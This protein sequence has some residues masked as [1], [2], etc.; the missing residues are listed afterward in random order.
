MVDMIPKPDFLPDPFEWIFIPAGSVELIRPP[1][2]KV[3]SLTVHVDS[4]YM[5]KYPITNAQFAV[6]VKERGRPQRWHS[7]FEEP[8]F[9]HPLQP[10]FDLLW[11]DAMKFCEW[12][13]EKTGRLVTLPTDAQWQRAAQGDDNRRF[14]WGD[15]WDVTYCNTGSSDIRHTTPVT[16]YPQG[17]SPYGVMDMVG[18]IQEWCLTDPGIGEN[19]LQYRMPDASITELWPDSRIFKGG[20]YSTTTPRTNTSN[21]RPLVTE[22]GVCMI[23]IFSYLCGIRLV[24]PGK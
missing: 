24:T 14:P 21:P 3:A 19:S 1:Y 23:Q 9:N 4:F 13:T 16:Q 8:P 10:V 12:I 18:N 5:A 15:T 6:Y 7:R 11:Y 22:Y 20:D 2:A 17:A